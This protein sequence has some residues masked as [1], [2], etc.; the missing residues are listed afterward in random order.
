MIE[1]NSMSTGTLNNTL[2]VE[3][4]HSA[5]TLLE[6]KPGTVAV[7]DAA[8]MKKYKADVDREQDMVKRSTAMD[9]SATMEK[10][11]DQRT[12]QYNLCRTLLE[13]C[14]YETDNAT[15]MACKNMVEAKLFTP[16]PTSGLKDSKLEKTALIRGF[17]VDCRKV[18]DET[19]MSLFEGLEDALDRL[20]ML[21]EK[22]ELNYVKRTF[23]MAQTT[24]GE[25]EQLRRACDDDLKRIELTLTYFANSMAEADATKQ[26]AAIET[27]P[28]ITKLA[29]QYRTLLKYRA[30]MAAKAKAGNEGSNEGQADDPDMP[31]ADDD[32][33]AEAAPATH[34]DDAEAEA[35]AAEA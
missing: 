26:S 31:Q 19:M 12:L 17:V 15:K 6:Q 35:P 22:Y 21:N 28:A 8:L 5:I 34:V 24:P 4:H 30:T 33:A 10:L 14:F 25:M 16:Y 32:A 9:V 13:T 29:D 27:M 11:D 23:E 1:I 3:Y 20:E 18:L 2:H 7:I